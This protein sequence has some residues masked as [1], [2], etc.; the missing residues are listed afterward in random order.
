MEK[1]KTLLAEVFKLLGNSGNGKLFE[2]LGRQINI[3]YTQDEKV[4][5]RGLRSAYFSDLDE[6]RKACELERRKPGITIRRPI[7]VGIAVYQLTRLRMPEF[8]YY[9][10]DRY[11]DRRDF[12]PRLNKYD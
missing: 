5:D 2:A 10:L 9:F 6:I 11:F 7:H 4:I 12:L 1:S 8:D 3:I